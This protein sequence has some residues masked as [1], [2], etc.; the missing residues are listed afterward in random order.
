MF[1]SELIY[2]DKDG[3]HYKFPQNS[4]K[5]CLNYPCIPNMELLKSD[6]AKFGCKNYLDSNIFDLS[7]SKT[8]NI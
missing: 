1:T 8:K 6:F 4:C 5:R 3:F 7:K 2:K